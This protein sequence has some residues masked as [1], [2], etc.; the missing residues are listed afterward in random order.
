MRGTGTCFKFGSP[1]EL[2]LL[3]PSERHLRE[4]RLHFLFGLERVVNILCGGLGPGG[5]WGCR[6][7]RR[8]FRGR[9]T[10]EVWLFHA[11]CF[12]LLA[13]LRCFSLIIIINLGTSLQVHLFLLELEVF[14]DNTESSQ[15][16]RGSI[17]IK[18]GEGKHQQS[19]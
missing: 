3:G 1:G 16:Y 17:D 9:A 8:R 15:S 19:S 14:G 6:F 18:L 4:R 7:R 2:R 12:P 11:L 10:A 5:S 13:E